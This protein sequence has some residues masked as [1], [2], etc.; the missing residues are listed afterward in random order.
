MTSIS[1][2]VQGF[3]GPCK[4]RPLQADSVRAFL[5]DYFDQSVIAEG[6]QA[7]A[8]AMHDTLLNL[9]GQQT[10]VQVRA[11]VALFNEHRT[12]EED[13]TDIDTYTLD[14]YSPCIPLTGTGPLRDPPDN[15]F[16]T[17]T[18]FDQGQEACIDAFFPVKYLTPYRRLALS[19]NNEVQ[20]KGFRSFLADNG[21]NLETLCDSNVG[22]LTETLKR[23]DHL[24]PVF[25]EQAGAD[26]DT[27]RGAV[28]KELRMIAGFAAKRDFTG[29]RFQNAKLICD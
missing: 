18:H 14:Y 26:F 8:Q 13:P 5:A 15:L 23:V 29:Y 3:R 7:E 22:D 20:G 21:V 19:F 16:L 6:H 9:A 17:A 25:K 2:A 27:Y 12:H 4:A 10:L 28:I 11:S 1:Y 24:L